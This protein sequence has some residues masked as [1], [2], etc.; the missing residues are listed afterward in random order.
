MKRREFIAV[1]I[2]LVLFLVMVAMAWFRTTHFT[3]GELETRFK[4]RES[5]MDMGTA[6][7]PNKALE[8][9]PLKPK[10]VP[11]PVPDA[12][13]VT[14][15]CTKGTFV[16]EF[17]KDWSPRG[18]GRVY[19]LVTSGF[20]DDAAFFRVIE[21]KL[22]Q[23]GIAGDPTVN[24]KWR[25]KQ[26][27]DDPAKQSNARG[28]ISFAATR[29]IDTRTTQL[30]INLTD[31]IVPLDEMGF[32]PVGKVTEGMEAVVD[33]LYSG[34][35]DSP[36]TGKGPS[37]TRLQSEGNNYLKQSFPKLDYIIKATVIEKPATPEKPASEGVS[38]AEPSETNKDG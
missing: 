16:A 27:K 10:A 21:G 38:L 11:K 20:Y 22:A 12:F 26:I 25:R 14:F 5:P 7:A 15:E 23:F 1:G 24:A 33:N 8:N 28:T 9:E 32:A 31:N 6:A 3:Q 36:P 18:V 2:V 30:F 34:Y 19:E 17:Y 13:E 37:Q 29:E 35:G 4:E